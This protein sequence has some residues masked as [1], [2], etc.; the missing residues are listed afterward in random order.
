MS[1][2]TP[3]HGAEVA[4]TVV[5]ERLF[6]DPSRSAFAILDGAAMPDLLARLQADA[7]DHACLYR[8]ELDPDLAEC[9]PYLVRLQADSPFTRWVL[10]DGWGSSWGIYVLAAATLHDLRRH[11]R[12]FLRVKGPDGKSLYFRYYDPRVL[13]EYLPT[14]NAEEIRIVFGPVASFLCE[15]SGGSGLIAF[16][17]HGEALKRQVVELATSR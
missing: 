1:D 4:V 16:E 10:A 9:A 5:M 17:R 8:G 6:A 13:R 2:T 11:F 3:L 7:P 14:C 12:G 15:S